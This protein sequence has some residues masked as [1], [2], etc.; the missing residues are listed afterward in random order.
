MEKWIF[1]ALYEGLKITSMRLHCCP[2][3]ARSPSVCCG[4]T[5]VLL[6]T[7]PEPHSLRRDS[8]PSSHQLEPPAGR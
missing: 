5:G 3:V 7:A 6:G 8:F 1:K 4:L 2:K